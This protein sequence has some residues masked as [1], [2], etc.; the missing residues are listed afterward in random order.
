MLHT[1]PTDTLKPQFC[2]PHPPNATPPCPGKVGLSQKSQVVPPTDRDPGR[3]LGREGWGKQPE[4]K[5]QG[6][7]WRQLPG[8]AH[9]PV[10]P[11]TQAQGQGWALSEV[12]E[13]SR[14]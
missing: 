14:G 6:S 3:K 10:P 2:P 1:L 13:L 7:A 5:A 4:T 9:G 8:G 11:G 12:S